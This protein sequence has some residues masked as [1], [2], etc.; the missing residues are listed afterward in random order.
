LQLQGTAAAF[1]DSIGRL[2]AFV[3]LQ[4]RS[5][6]TIRELDLA[7]RQLRPNVLDSTT[8]LLLAAVERTRKQL[9]LTRPQAC[10]LFGA[11]DTTRYIDHAADGQPL[12]PS[13]YDQLFLNR[14]ITNPVDP[15]VALNDAGDELRD[16]S[17]TLAKGAATIAAA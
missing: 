14:A 17:V 11:I 1:K 4:R 2:I 9:S 12:L 3:R 5:R 15:Q 6:W 10:A 8:L 7:I 16:T 13:Q